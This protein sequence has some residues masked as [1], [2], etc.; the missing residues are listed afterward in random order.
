MVTALDILSP[1][2]GV[3]IGGFS[4]HEAGKRNHV[5][6]MSLRSLLLDHCPWC[7]GYKYC[8]LGASWFCVPLHN[9]PNPSSLVSSRLFGPTYLLS[10]SFSEI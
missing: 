7:M 10:R 3:K 9:R 6:D 4:E 2:K 8:P 1:E 5:S